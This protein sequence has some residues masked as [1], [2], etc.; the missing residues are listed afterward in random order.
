[1]NTIKV[2]KKSIIILIILTVGLV[3]T[4]VL[5]KKPTFFKSKAAADIDYPGA[6][7][8]T[9][10][11]GQELTY[12]GEGVYTIK[13]DKIKL[14]IKDFKKLLQNKTI[15]DTKIIDTYIDQR[16]NQTYERKEIKPLSEIPKECGSIGPSFDFKL[17]QEKPYLLIDDK[18]EIV[19]INDP[20]RD[21][22]V[23]VGSMLVTLGRFAGLP[24]VWKKGGDNRYYPLSVGEEDP[25]WVVRVVRLNAVLGEG[26]YLRFWYGKENNPYGQPGGLK[27][28]CIKILE[29]VE[30]LLLEGKWLP[31]FDEL[32]EQARRA[33][34]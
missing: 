2:S 23:P 14:G 17:L 5:V 27:E 8:I 7:N 19:E 9:D 30:Q 3:V 1:M 31:S 26:D 18:G 29:R 6:L 11:S 15:D 22:L 25:R 21:N 10:S 32:E 33:V 34:G 24:Y 28:G 12:K 20:I 16:D 4:L 13:G